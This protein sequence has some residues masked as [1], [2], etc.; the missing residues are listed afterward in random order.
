M[1]DDWCAANT[2]SLLLDITD[3]SFIDSP[4]GAWSWTA[5]DGMLDFGQSVDDPWRWPSLYER[6]AGFGSE[7]CVRSS[8]E[9]VSLGL[10]IDVWDWQVFE[11]TYE[12]VL[13]DGS[14]L[15]GDISGPWRTD[16]VDCD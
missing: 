9:V 5:S 1:T 14:T 7:G 15:S 3:A 11:G 10:S 13:D 6:Y 16:I 4:A 2:Q 8:S 12:A